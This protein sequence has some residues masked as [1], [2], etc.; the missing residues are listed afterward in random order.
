M[1]NAPVRYQGRLACR[2]GMDANRSNGITS[3]SIVVRAITF[4]LGRQAQ[5]AA[6]IALQA[7]KVRFDRKSYLPRILDSEKMPDDLRIM[8]SLPRQTQHGIALLADLVVGHD[9]ND[10]CRFGYRGQA[11][12]RR[13]LAVHQR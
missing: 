6:M 1:V 8:L 13:N 10:L 12:C 4:D 11:R 2:F 7:R 9:L 5:E 3:C